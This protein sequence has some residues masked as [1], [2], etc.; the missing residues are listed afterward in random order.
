MNASRV[1][2][3]AKDS[4]CNGKAAI[5][6]DVSQR[7]GMTQVRVVG[8]ETTLWLKPGEFRHLTAKEVVKA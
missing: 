8:E 6:T 5:I 1:L 7:S 4:G 2:I 3:T